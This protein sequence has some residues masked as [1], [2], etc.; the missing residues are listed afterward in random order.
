M[1]RRF[2]G[3]AALAVMTSVLGAVDVGAAGTESPD[4]DVMV[5][6]FNVL[7][8][9]WASS[10]WYPEIDEHSLLAIEARRPLI[11]E[12]LASA[13]P[14]ADVVCLQE[15][16]A[17]EYPHLAAALGPGYVGLRSSNAPE[18][19]ADWVIPPLVWEPNGTALFLRSDAFDDIELDDIDLGTGNHAVRFSGTSVGGHSVGAWSIHLDSDRQNNRNAELD[20]V[21]ADADRLAA[22]VDI[23][24]GDFNEDTRVGT[25]AGRVKRAGFVDALTAVGLDGPTHPWSEGY[26]RSRRWAVI[27][28]IV[29]RGADPTSGAIVDAGTS[30]IEDQETRIEE[31]LRRMGSDHYAVVAHVALR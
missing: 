26:N 3:L 28:H 18:F 2:V 13:T 4:D 1:I 19:W 22:D 8:P 21:V 31:Y 30:T 24:C 27:D 12:Y 20:T 6:S 14:A 17:T 16:T 11:Q 9:I 25:A 5:V 10:V 23:V 29:V 7:G 15:V